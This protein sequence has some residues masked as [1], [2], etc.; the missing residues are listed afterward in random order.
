MSENLTVRHEENLWTCTDQQH[1]LEHVGFIDL[2]ILI[3]KEMGIRKFTLTFDCDGKAIDGATATFDF[4][5][6]DT[7]IPD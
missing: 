5:A 2:V 1:R 7:Y 4:G 3:R 6:P